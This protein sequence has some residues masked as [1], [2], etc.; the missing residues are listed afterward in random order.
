[1]IDT[2]LLVELMFSTGC[3]VDTAAAAKFSAELKAKGSRMSIEM[4]F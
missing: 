4:F 2:K 3:K 1:M